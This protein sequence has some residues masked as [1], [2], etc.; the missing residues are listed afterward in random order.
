[1]TI[2]LGPMSKMFRKKFKKTE[3]KIFLCPHICYFSEVEVAITRTGKL[4]FDCL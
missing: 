1:M 2:K 4:C 3:S